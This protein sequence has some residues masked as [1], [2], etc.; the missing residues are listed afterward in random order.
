MGFIFRDKITVIYDSPVSDSSF[1]KC[2]RII[3]NKSIALFLSYNLSRKDQSC[4]NNYV[5]K[6]ANRT[7]RL[8]HQIHR[9]MLK[10]HTRA[11]THTYTHT[12]T[13]ART[14]ASTHVRTHIHRESSL[15]QFSVIRI[16]SFS[17]IYHKM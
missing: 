15:F 17:G 4:H 12:H 11:R 14:H 9:L 16:S 10:Q 6:T 7:D 2:A 8:K 1:K 13:H 5:Q 3:G